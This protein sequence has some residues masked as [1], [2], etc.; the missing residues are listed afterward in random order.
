MS[1]LVQVAGVWWN[2]PE[3]YRPQ[4]ARPCKS[5]GQVILMAQTPKDKWAPLNPDGTSHFSNCPQ[6]A[7]FRRPKPSPAPEAT[8]SRDSD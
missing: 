2:V 4:Q 8:A 1:S 3:G 5:C 6:A 7:Q